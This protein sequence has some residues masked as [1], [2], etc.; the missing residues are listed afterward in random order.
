MMP[1]QSGLH[2]HKLGKV[3]GPEMG[4]SWMKTHAQVP[5]PLLDEA[6]GLIRVYFSSRPENGV[7]M[8]SYVDLDANDPLRILDINQSQLLALGKPGSFDEH[9]IMPSCAVRHA[10]LVYLYYSGW[11]RATTVPYTNSTGLAIS[12]DGGRTFR[13]AGDGPVL[14][15]SLG[16]P[17]S[18]TSPFVM[19]HD[20]A[21]RMW[22]CSGTDWPLVDGK[23]EHVYDIKEAHSDD[24]I[25]WRPSGKVSLPATANEQALTRPWVV[26]LGANWHLYYCHRNASDFRDGAGAYRIAAATS[27]DLKDWRQ[28]GADGPGSGDFAAQSEPQWDARAQAYPALLRVGSRLLM[29]Y[30]GNGFGAGGFGVAY[31]EL[32]HLTSK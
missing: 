17:Y 15:K 31:A 5:T 20:G 10:N 24:G 28:L 30:N 27:A 1:S 3:F 32:D 18:A 22:Y 7:S 12:E 11:S 6:A 21:W 26:Q 19:Q 2:W 4:P 9:G 23:Y 25:F 29:F 16:D 8:M 13:R 14:A